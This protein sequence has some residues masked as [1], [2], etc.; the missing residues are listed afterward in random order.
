MKLGVSHQR[1]ESLTPERLRY[2]RQMGAEALEIR[3]PAPEATP[4]NLAKIKKE[5]EAEGLD[6]FLIMQA[7]R[8]VSFDGMVVPDHVPIIGPEKSKRD[9]GEAYISGYIRA[10]MDATKPR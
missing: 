10:L 2:L 1:Q 3:I 5:V 7:L 6:M 4:Q 8:D 9:I